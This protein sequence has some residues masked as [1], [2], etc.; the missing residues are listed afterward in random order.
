MGWRELCAFVRF[1][2]FTSDWVSKDDWSN[3]SFQVFLLFQVPVCRRGWLLRDQEQ[4][5]PAVSG[6]HHYC[7]TGTRVQQRAHGTR[8][9]EN[10]C[11]RD[12]ISSLIGGEVNVWVQVMKRPNC[13]EA[14]PLHPKC[15]SCSEFFNEDKKKKKKVPSLWVSVLWTLSRVCKNKVV[16]ATNCWRCVIA[17][18]LNANHCTIVTFSAQPSS[19]L[20]PWLAP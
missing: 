16:A 6:A 20:C 17:F 4:R 10:E 9:R 13:N 15:I 7:A 18:I 5:D 3:G 8:T 11:S 1:C 14:K 2:R 12:K 19:V